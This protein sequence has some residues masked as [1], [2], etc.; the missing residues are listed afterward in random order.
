MLDSYFTPKH[1][2]LLK[3]NEKKKDDDLRPH[4]IKVKSIKFLI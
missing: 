3:K 1:G 4:E 2:W